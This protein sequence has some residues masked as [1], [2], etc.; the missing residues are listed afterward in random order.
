MTPKQPELVV[1]RDG[2]PVADQAQGI[3]DFKEA[4]LRTG[5]EPMDCTSDLRLLWR[6]EDAGFKGYD[7][8]TPTRVMDTVLREIA[9][10]RVRA[11]RMEEWLH[12]YRAR[13][14]LPSK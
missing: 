5:R 6:G 1:T 14:N 9:Y 8:H 7:Y 2:V 12:A 4:C 11:E 13:H 10:L 3:R